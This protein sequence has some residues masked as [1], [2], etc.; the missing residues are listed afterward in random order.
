MIVSPQLCVYYESED[1]K[2]LHHQMPHDTK[3]N[4]HI[5]VSALSNWGLQLAD[6]GCM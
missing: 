5:S 2:W 6:I 3:H 4:T 1:A